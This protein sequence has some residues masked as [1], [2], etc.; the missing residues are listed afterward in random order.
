M[1]FP[2]AK[3]HARFLQ[4]H[5]NINPSVESPQSS[6]FMHYLQTPSFIERTEVVILVLIQERKRKSS[7]HH[8]R[9]GSPLPFLLAGCGLKGK[10]SHSP[11]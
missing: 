3:F 1:H 7:C 5:N 6:I 8:Y 10:V 11:P 2:F 4:L 9:L